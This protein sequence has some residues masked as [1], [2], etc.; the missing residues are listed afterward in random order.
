VAAE[1]TGGM[2]RKGARS[3]H[4]VAN[5]VVAA[6]MA[7]ALIT[8]QLDGPRMDADGLLG[9]LLGVISAVLAAAVASTRR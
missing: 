6:G 7:L 5:I 3:N 4:P 9:V 2:T 8:F 1:H